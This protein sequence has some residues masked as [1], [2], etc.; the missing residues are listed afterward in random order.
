MNFDVLG[1][2]APYGVWYRRQHGWRRLACGCFDASL[3]G[4]I[5]L[6]LDHKNGSYGALGFQPSRL[7]STEDGTLQ[8][9]VNA[10]GLFFRA[11]LD[12]PRIRGLACQA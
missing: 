2:A 12:D 6:W 10:Y 7:A 1:F 4:R 9:F 8:P 5:E 3:A 11:K